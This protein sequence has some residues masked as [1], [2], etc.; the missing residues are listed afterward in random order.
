[1]RQDYCN[2]RRGGR[3]RQSNKTLATICHDSPAPRP[4][5]HPAAAR[6]AVLNGLQGQ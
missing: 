5:P 3:I 2:R 4:I 1:M 6:F